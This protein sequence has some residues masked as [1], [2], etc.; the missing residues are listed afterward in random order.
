MCIV[1]LDQMTQIHQDQANNKNNKDNG[2]QNKETKFE[3][4]V[5]QA[6]EDNKDNQ[7]GLFLPRLLEPQAKEDHNVLVLAFDKALFP[8]LFLLLKL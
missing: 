1:D 7:E 4:G 8:S 5:E 6:E 3:V 2:I